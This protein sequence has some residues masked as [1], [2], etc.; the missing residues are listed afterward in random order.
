MPSTPAGFVPPNFA[1]L[2]TVRCNA[3]MGERAASAPLGS[4]RDQWT[5]SRAALRA[6]QALL[7]PPP[8]PAQQ[9]QDPEIGWGV[10]LP[11]AAD[12]TDDQRRTGSDAPEPIRALL[13]ER[14]ASKVL[15]YRTDT[16]ALNTLRD[17]TTCTD[18]TFATAPI[19]VAAGAIPDYLL[20]VGSPRDIPWT[21]QFKL[22]QVRKVGRL[23]LD[24]TGLANYV[25][26]LIDNWKGSTTDYSSPV[27]WAV[28]H[29]GDITPL[30]RDAVAAPLY[31]LY[32]QDTDLHATAFIDGTNVHA[33][34]A[35]LVAALKTSRPSVVVTTSH[36]NT[37]PLNDTD[38]MRRQLGL[39]VDADRSIIEPNELLNQWQP[40]GAIWFAQACCSAG[41]QRPSIYSN[42]FDTS[43]DT[44]RVLDGV[45]AVGAVTSPLPAALLGAA[46]PLRAFIGHVEPTFEWTLWF[47]PTKAQLTDWVCRLMYNE[48]CRGA[49]VGLGMANARLY[50]AVGTLL[51][52]HTQALETHAVAP[53]PQAR[54]SALDLA[55]YD[56]VTAYDRAST[57]LLGD[58]T[59]AIPTPAN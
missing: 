27:I 44:G 19:G 42:L 2:A 1:A 3:W 36:G 25:H 5:L 15:R 50:T 7:P 59:V 41:A 38:E 55:L 14:P 6:D 43:T 31:D 58:P 53:D 37:S 22:N 24:D 48:V 33:T 28:N 26:A 34:K 29:G 56:K 8:V 23:D 16:D 54:R 32:H 17:Y 45:S 13:A 46:R 11:D 47:P 21:L 4:L 52:Q 10:I 18:I 51:L 35:L 57:V 9:W 49:P 20:I 39:L 40:D 30:M 12:L